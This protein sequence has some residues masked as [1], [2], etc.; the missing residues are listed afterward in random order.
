MY[1]SFDPLNTAGF[2]TWA[3]IMMLGVILV[4]FIAFVCRK[5]KKN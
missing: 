1:F 5:T 3:L 4:V 2:I